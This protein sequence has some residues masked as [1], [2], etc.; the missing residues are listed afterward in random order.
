MLFWNGSFVGGV[1]QADGELIFDNVATV[2]GVFQ[3]DSIVEVQLLVV[4]AE[5]VDYHVKGC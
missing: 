4:E 1:G 5:H 3:E 2:F